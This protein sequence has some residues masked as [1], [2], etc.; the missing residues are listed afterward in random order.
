MEELRRNGGV[1]PVVSKGVLIG[2]VTENSLTKA[3]GDDYSLLD[4][5]SRAMDE[6]LTIPPYASGAEA[7]RLLSEMEQPTLVVVDDMGRVTGLISPS[8]L[9]PRRRMKP[10]PASVGGMATPFGVY[11]T[12]GAQRGGVSLFAVMATGA[13]MFC[14]LVTGA[15]LASWALSPLDHTSLSEPAKTFIDWAGAI[16]LFLLIMRLAPLA[17]THG[18]E[19]MTVHAI[20]RGE[21]LTLDVV[22]RMPRVHP[23]CGTNL[24]VAVT[25]F[26]VISQT[27]WVE[28]YSVRVLVAVVVTLYSWKPLGS[29]AQQFITTRKP[30]E[31][32]LRS[33]IKAGIELIDKY[34]VA[35]F[36]SVNVP[37]RIWNSGLLHV[38]AGSILAWLLLEGVL[39]LFHLNLPGVRVGTI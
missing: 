8:D 10:R 29:F 1:L 25:L 5:C 33:G 24:A 39:M 35:R 28:D 18:A 31:R 3:L 17:G 6:A 36:S 7:L 9:F 30:S 12:S 38:V 20:E 26:S 13:V 15:V 16:G 19:H 14:M 11:L 27:E 23:R 21:E 37:T 32:Q 34:S 2:I 22:S 4:S